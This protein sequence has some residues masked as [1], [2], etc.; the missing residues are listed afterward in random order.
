MILRMGQVVLKKIKK[1]NQLH[2]I[3]EIRILKLNLFRKK[4]R[5]ILNQLL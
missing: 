3:N 4:M 1:Y 2:L 5:V